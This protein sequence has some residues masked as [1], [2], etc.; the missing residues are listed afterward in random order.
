MKFF[1]N[2]NILSRFL[3]VWIGIIAVSCWN[4]TSSPTPPLP[5]LT[6][7]IYSETP[8][9]TLT[10]PMD[11]NPTTT[12]TLST[13]TNTIDPEYIILSPL[14]GIPIEDLPS[15][16][17]N[18]FSPPPPGSDNPHQGVD[19]SIVDPN[20]NVA[21]SGTEVRAA[22]SGIVASVIKDRFPYGNA[23]LIETR[24]DLISP[25]LI[26]NFV[27]PTPAPL[28]ENHPILTC[29]LIDENTH[30]EQNSGHD[31]ENRSLYLLYAHLE[32]QVLFQPGDQ[33]MAGQK[34]GTVGSSGNALNPH[35]HLELRVGSSG[36]K[37]PSIAHYDS[38]ASLEEMSYYCLWR[39]SN[40]FQLLNPMI[41][42]VTPSP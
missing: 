18:K 41:L 15:L 1:T 31:E 11:Q 17:S 20:S 21:I 30:P 26:Q 24:I 32:E 23:I 19:F 35:L 22:I 37:F 28:Q 36:A 9:K 33:I 40:A 42:F 3:I 38:S 16:I 14:T 13:L 29:P 4:P 12:R 5:T 34:L 8:Q 27:L 25:L 6:H 39:V 2:K 10:P 7:T